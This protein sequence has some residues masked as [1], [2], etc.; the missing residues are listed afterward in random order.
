MTITVKGKETRL[1]IKIHYI[2]RKTGFLKEI[3][4]I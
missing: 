1:G 4:R 2:K 3:V